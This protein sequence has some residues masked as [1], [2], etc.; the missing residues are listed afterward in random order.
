MKVELMNFLIHIHLNV[1]I[2]QEKE[3]EEIAFARELG[4]TKMNIIG[5]IQKLSEKS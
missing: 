4:V 2:L 5:T 3:A 1:D